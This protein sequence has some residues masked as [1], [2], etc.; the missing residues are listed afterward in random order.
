MGYNLNRSAPHTYVALHVG[1]TA[2]AISAAAKRG[3]EEGTWAGDYD[4][5]KDRCPDVRWLPPQSHVH[6][7]RR[8]D[9]GMAG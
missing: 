5:P 8:T 6:A 7:Q 4:G 2:S 9:S 3:V 1:P